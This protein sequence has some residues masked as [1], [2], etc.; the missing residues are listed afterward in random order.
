MDEIEAMFPAPNAAAGEANKTMPA[1]HTKRKVVDRSMF[2]GFLM[3]KK[4][5]ISRCIN[6][7][8]RSHA[9]SCVF[10]T[11]EVWISFVAEPSPESGMLDC[12]PRRWVVARDLILYDGS[13]LSP[14]DGV[15]IVLKILLNM[16]SRET[17]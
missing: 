17:R 10:V 2:G 15:W 13:K 16:Q 6:S 7:S 3:D 1:K 5:V 12:T 8:R 9:R 4:V 11:A 14:G